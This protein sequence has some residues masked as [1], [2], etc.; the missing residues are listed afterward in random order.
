MAGPA[1][2]LAE[3]TP[4]DVRELHFFVRCCQKASD[5]RRFDD[6]AHGLNGGLWS[7]VAGREPPDGK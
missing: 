1:V 7:Q 3:M 4:Q 6:A 2:A 5:I